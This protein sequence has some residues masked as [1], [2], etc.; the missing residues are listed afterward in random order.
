MSYEMIE[1]LKE[2][3]VKIIL[4]YKRNT[5]CPRWSTYKE[6]M[7]VVHMGLYT[8]EAEKKVAKCQIHKTIN[9]STTM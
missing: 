2:G 4:E 7:R 6:K 5:E 8:K 3:Y 1:Y 9:D